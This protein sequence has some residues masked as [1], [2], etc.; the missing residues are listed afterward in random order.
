MSHWNNWWVS[1][2]AGN[3]RYGPP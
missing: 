2:V 3:S 1:A